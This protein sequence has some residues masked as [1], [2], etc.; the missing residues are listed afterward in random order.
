MRHA[1]DEYRKTLAKMMQDFE[2]SF[3]RKNK[4]RMLKLRNKLNFIFN[5]KSAMID[6]QLNEN[7]KALKRKMYSKMKESENKI[8]DKFGV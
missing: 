3:M 8:K 5:K 7:I 6:S 1:K 4:F 2:L